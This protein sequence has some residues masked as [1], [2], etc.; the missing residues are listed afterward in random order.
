MYRRMNPIYRPRTNGRRI[1]VFDIETYPMDEPYALGFYEPSMPKPMIIR[2]KKCIRIFYEYVLKYRYRNW[3]WYAHFGGR[4]DV[5]FLMKQLIPDHRQFKGIFQGGSIISLKVLHH[6]DHRHATYFLDSYA[7]LKGSLDKLTRDFQVE[8]QKLKGIPDNDFAKLHQMYLDRDPLFDKY[9]SHDCLGLY[10]V[11]KKFYDVVEGEGGRIGTTISATSMKTFRQGFLTQPMT[12]ASKEVNDFIRENAYYGGR[13]EVFR[14]YLP[15]D[16]YYCF[17]INSLYPAVMREGNFATNPPIKQNNP[18]ANCYREQEGVSIAKVRCPKDL[19]IPVLPA[20]K[21][22]KLYFPCGTF[23]GMWDNHLLRKARE[24]GYKIQVKETWTWKAHPIFKKYVDTFHP[25]KNASKQAGRIAEA[26][27]YKYLLNTLYGK[28]GQ[29]QEGC[30]IRR[31]K[32]DELFPEG[33]IEFLDE[34]TSMVRVKS[35]AKGKHFFPHIAVHVTALAQLKLYEQM[36]LIM[37]KG[38]MLAYCDTDSVFTDIEIP[39]GDRLGQMGLDYSF[40][41]AIFLTPKQ[42]YI[43]GEKTKKKNKGYRERY[44]R[45]IGEQEYLRALFGDMEGFDVETEPQMNTFLVSMHRHGTPVSM[46]VQRKSMQSY[47]DKRK[48]LADYDTS[49]YPYYIL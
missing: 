41:G 40:E 11:L 45:E 10:E 9:L 42:Y 49:P 27:V 1:G 8:H 17:D 35:E 29:R 5:L 4:F 37:E 21:D 46:D 33:L 34:D 16:T 23:T 36:E 24:V 12:M 32:P 3:R 7:L 25:K 6:K 44:M 22:K 30:E 43:H 28:T 31:C 47:Y 2:G 48:I 13:T 20:K 14:M 38:G 18:T 39:T 19:Y 26:T 15:D